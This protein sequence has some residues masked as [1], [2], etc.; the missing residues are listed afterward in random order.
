MTGG[1]VHL[2]RQTEHQKARGVTSKGRMVLVGVMAVYCV[3]RRQQKAKIC[4][5][6]I[7]GRSPSNPFAFEE[8][9]LFA[10]NSVINYDKAFRDA[11]ERDVEGG[12][13]CQRC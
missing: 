13:Q 8:G 5:C 3:R 1:V 4:F 10:A 2:S 9:K 12:G 11:M 6:V 7:Y